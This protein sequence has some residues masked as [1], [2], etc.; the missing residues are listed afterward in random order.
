MSRKVK[1]INCCYSGTFASPR[2]I[3]EENY[4]YAKFLLERM[5]NVLYCKETGKTKTVEHEQYCKHYI[6]TEISPNASSITELEKMIEEY[7][8]QL[9]S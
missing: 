9:V 4:E 5:K 8:K 2:R 3:T 7:E 6:K 1:C